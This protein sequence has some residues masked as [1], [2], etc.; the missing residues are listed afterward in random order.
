MQGWN[1]VSVGISGV[2]G[3][4]RLDTYLSDAAPGQGILLD[5]VSLKCA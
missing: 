3:S 5:D 4:L 1:R 2:E